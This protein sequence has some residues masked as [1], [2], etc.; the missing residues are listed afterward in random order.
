[1]DFHIAG[2]FV[3]KISEQSSDG[4]LILV[5]H[6]H[7]QFVAKSQ[8]S[9]G[10]IDIRFQI[11]G[12]LIRSRYDIATSGNQFSVNLIKFKFKFVQVFIKVNPCQVSKSSG[13]TDK[14]KVQTPF[15]FSKEKT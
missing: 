10:F 9:T 3:K 14:L 7:T 11:I 1:M 2:P 12:K 13:K 8:S 4:F 6:N 5:L 15:N